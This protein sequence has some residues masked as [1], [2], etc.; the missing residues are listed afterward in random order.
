V[1]SET[2]PAA[3]PETAPLPPASSSA[4][5]EAALPTPRP[6][7]ES[8][9]LRKA[10][11][12]SELPPPAPPTAEDLVHEAQQM[13]MRGHF[14]AAIGKAEDVLKADPKPG[15]AMQ[16]YEIIGTCS[17]ALRDAAAAQQA[18]S[19]LSAAKREMVKAACEKRGVTI[20]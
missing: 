18:A 2:A 4:Q 7:V 17:C 6:K 10:T 12:E 9:E 11:A 15:Q 16:A 3:E 5:P 20:E 19:H 13:W 14:G 1:P 8:P